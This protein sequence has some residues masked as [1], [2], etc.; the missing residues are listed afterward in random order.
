MAINYG[1]NLG[2]STIETALDVAGGLQGLRSQQ[3][4]MSM[5]KD[6]QEAEKQRGAAMKE[7]V[8]HLQGNDAGSVARMASEHPDLRG[9]FIEAI[10]FQDALTSRP[11]IEVAKDVLAGRIPPRQAYEQRVLEIE[12]QGGDARYLRQALTEDSDEDLMVMAEKDL[13]MLNPKGYESYR[14][15][16][17]GGG[18]KPTAKIQEFEMLDKMEPGP[19]KDAFASMI[20]AEDTIKIKGIEYR[21]NPLTN[22]YEA[23]LDAASETVSTQERALADMEADKSSRLDY[24]KNK[25]KWATGRPKYEGRIRSAK[26]DRKVMDSTAEEI[27]NT[28]SNY[29]AKYG[30]ALR[31]IS[32]T[33]AQKL[34]GLYQ[35]MLANSAFSTLISLKQAGGTLG[36]ISGSELDLLKAK[37]GE[38][39]QS[40]QVEEQLRVLDQIMEANERA[41]Q[42][43]ESEYTA[44]NDLYSGSYDDMVQNQEFEVDALEQARAAIARGVPRDKVIQRLQENGVNAS[45]L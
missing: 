30:S 39:N 10:N 29:S 33:D 40:G 1:A 11:R 22:R 21:K 26:N 20:G 7:F 37:Q 36:A 18:L 3:L 24:S 44:T 32:G 45:N 43:I 5:I 41:I 12:S 23:A 17:S 19:R 16:I 4:K 15:A 42:N 31:G 14:R 6:K 25:T 28:L 9:E 38:L 13:A 27:R 35:T 2:P 8:G 34:K